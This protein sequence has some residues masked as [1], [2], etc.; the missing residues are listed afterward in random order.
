MSKHSGRNPR[1]FKLIK[2]IKCLPDFN[3][4]FERDFPLNLRKLLKE[5]EL[6]FQF[7]KYAWSQNKKFEYFFLEN[8][9]LHELH[10]Y[11]T[12]YRWDDDTKF[13]HH[14]DQDIESIQRA[15]S[16]SGDIEEISMLISSIKSK[17]RTSKD[18]A[19]FTPIK[20]YV[21]V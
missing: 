11:S 14:D 16:T 2:H 18:H 19:Q 7:C 20:K 8:I 4:N 3:T 6:I 21:D 13:S 10:A 12:M 17:N 9:F 1:L 5:I 15:R